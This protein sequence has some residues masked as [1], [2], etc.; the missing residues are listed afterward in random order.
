MPR[1]AHALAPIAEHVARTFGRAMEVIDCGYPVW[2]ERMAAPTHLPVM[3]RVTTGRT[4]QPFRMKKRTG[5]TSTDRAK[6]AGRFST[7][8]QGE[9]R[10][11]ESR[12]PLPE[13][14]PGGSR[15]RE[16]KR[17]VDTV[18]AHVVVVVLDGGRSRGVTSPALDSPFSESAEWIRSFPSCYPLSKRRHR[19]GVPAR[20]TIGLPATCPC[21]ESR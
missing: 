5:L 16:E 3:T 13:H 18:G 19:N 6:L 1:L 8:C 4:W 15:G 2:S 10:G 7:P 21:P 11:F 14:A 20:G 9:G 17:V 12:R